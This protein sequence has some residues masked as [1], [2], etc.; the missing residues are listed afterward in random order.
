MIYSILTFFWYT[1]YHSHYHH[2]ENKE[3]VEEWWGLWSRRDFR[4]LATVGPGRLKIG[5]N[6]HLWLSLNITH[7]NHKPMMIFQWNIFIVYPHYIFL[8]GGPQSYSLIYNPHVTST[9]KQENSP[10]QLNQISY[11]KTTLRF[12]HKG[13]PRMWLNICDIKHFPWNAII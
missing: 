9:N 11:K 7:K 2:D 13:G 8:Q 3:K 5:G 10:S 4:Q 1:V 6:I 12:Q